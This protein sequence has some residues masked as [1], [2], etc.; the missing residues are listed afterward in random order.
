MREGTHRVPHLTRSTTPASTG[1]PLWRKDGTV[2]VTGGLGVLGR[3]TI[4]HL[5]ASHGIRRIMVVSRSGAATDGAAGFVDELSAQGAELHLVTGDAADR[6][7]LERALAS[8]PADQP[9]TAVVH[10]AGA[11]DDGVLT[12][13]T[14]ERADHVLRPKADAAWHLHELVT[15]PDV[16]FVA[17]SSLSSVLGP[18]GQ[19]S[20]AAANAFVDALVTRRRAAGLSG[21]ALGWGLWESR[22]GLTGDL[23]DADVRRMARS[24][25]RPLSDDQGLALLDLACATDAPVVF[26]LHL[27]TTA[28]GSGDA[29]VPPLL[30][31]LARTPGRRTAARATAPEPAAGDSLA[32]RLARAPE[33]EQDA[34]LLTLVRTHVAAVLGYDDPR[35]VGE[36]RTFVD[37]G[38]DSLRALQL[39]NRLN[40]AT[41]LRLPATLVFD[42]PTPVTLGRH[43]HTLLVPD[44]PAAGD[45][46]D[47]VTTS[48]PDAVVPDPTP[49]TGEG[50]EAIE[51]LRSA[52]SLQEVLDFIDDQLGQ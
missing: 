21:L 18:A 12:S 42:H 50:G 25:V 2:L 46:V 45:S 31:G 40:G 20:Y 26:P 14:P 16:A 22:S 8:I 52:A 3:M 39:R 6:G 32:E 7:V 38:F 29:D 28:L 44:A 48:R 34:Q 41:G 33:A 51:Q 11:L 35:T 27:D 43:L 24:G 9:L 47:G 49:A 15:D 37:I 19:G 10:L 4:R 36:R 30:R 17:F 23:G 1:G 13:L 5:V